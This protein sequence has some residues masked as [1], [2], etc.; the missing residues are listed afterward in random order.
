MALTFRNQSG[1]ARPAAGGVKK[2]AFIRVRPDE[3]R[4]LLPTPFYLPSVAKMQIG[5]H[6]FV[7]FTEYNEL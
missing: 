4:F 7:I 3:S 5:Y 6:I 1:F 2:T